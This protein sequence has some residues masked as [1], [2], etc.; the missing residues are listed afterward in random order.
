[1]KKPF[2]DRVL[3]P[4]TKASLYWT[5]APIYKRILAF[6]FDL[7]FMFPIQNITRGIHPTLPVILIA[8]YFILLDSSKWQATIGKRILGMKIEH[9][10]GTR[11]SV[12][13][14]SIRYFVKVITLALIGIGYWPLFKHKQAICDRIVHADVYAL[15]VKK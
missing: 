15:T 10:D 1:M 11:L 14:A 2:I 5:K 4:E 6:F 7:F 9:L 13:E 12:Y 8:A 3:T